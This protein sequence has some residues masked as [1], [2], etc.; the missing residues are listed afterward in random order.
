[1][2]WLR[3]R[4]SLRRMSRLWRLQSLQRLSLRRRLRRMWRLWRWL[5][6]SRS[7]M[8]RVRRLLCIV[9]PLPLVLGSCAF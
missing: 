5:D 7:A 8:G 2:P 6:R 9:G 1:L 3:R 4:E